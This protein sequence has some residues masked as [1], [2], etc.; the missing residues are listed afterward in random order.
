MQNMLEDYL[1]FASGEGTEDV[2]RLDLKPLMD[3]LA[4]EAQLC[5]RGFTCSIKGDPVVQVR[6]GAFSRLI[7]N[8]VSNAFRYAG[9]VRVTI[10]HGRETLVV[11]I[12]D[13]GPGIPGNKREDVFKP[14]F[15][16]DEARNQDAGGT[17]LGLVHCTRH[18]TQPWR[19]C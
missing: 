14:F 19:R 18:S 13:D 5:K 9:K 3:K 16:L 1:A 2:S 12:D 10:K 4:E 8:L 6:P 17:G 11:I 7:V 15:R